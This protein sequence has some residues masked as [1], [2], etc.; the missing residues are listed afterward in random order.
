MKGGD[1]RMQ[2]DR[3]CWLFAELERLLGDAEERADD[4]QVAGHLKMIRLTTR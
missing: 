2:H 1:P 3:I 4:W